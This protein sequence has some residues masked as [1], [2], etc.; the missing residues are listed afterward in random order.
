MTEP[1]AMAAAPHDAG[2]ADRVHEGT[3][4]SA[5]EREARKALARIEKQLER[6]DDA[7]RSSTPR[8]RRTS[9][10]TTCSPT[11]ATSSASSQ[12]EKETLELEWLEASEAVE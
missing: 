11:S 4:G 12:A 9:A 8:W 3:P 2:A 10:T 6:I 7:R 1:A 5:E